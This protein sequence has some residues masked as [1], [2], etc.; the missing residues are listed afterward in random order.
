VKTPR[1]LATILHCLK[2][3]E[4]LI[5]TDDTTKH[6]SGVEVLEKIKMSREMAVLLYYSA[7]K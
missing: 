2:L 1:E 4:S 5:E 7:S 6:E 3:Q